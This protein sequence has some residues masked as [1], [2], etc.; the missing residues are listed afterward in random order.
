[1]DELLQNSTVIEDLM[2]ELSVRGAFVCY[3]ALYALVTRNLYKSSVI[4]DKL[5]PLAIVLF[6]IGAFPVLFIMGIYKGISYLIKRRNEKRC[7]HCHAEGIFV[8]SLKFLLRE[9]DHLM[10]N[11][12]ETIVEYY[13]D[14]QNGFCEKMTLVGYE[15]VFMAPKNRWEEIYR[16]ESVDSNLED[17]RVQSRRYERVKLAVKQY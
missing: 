10:V 1:M 3:A 4:E 11:K 8:H 9:G 14:E 2:W 16:E 7:Y 6:F 13:W 5:D 17:E 12:Y 15:K